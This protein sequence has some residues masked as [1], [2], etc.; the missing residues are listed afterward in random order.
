MGHWGFSYVGLLYLLMLFIPNGIWTKYKPAGYEQV[1]GQEKK[2]LQL[3]ER[4]GQIGTTATVLVFRDFNLSS[5][6]PWSLWLAAS[7]VCMLLY[8]YCWFRYFRSDRRQQDF[9]R[10]WGPLPVPLA[11]LPVLAFL[12][13]GIYGKVLWLLLFTVLL[14]VGHIGIHWQHQAS[15]KHE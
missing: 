13:L 7:F 14:G 2:W 10:K 15:I 12:L 9:Y 8:E 4:I 11:T 6:T 3:L 1:A 5:L